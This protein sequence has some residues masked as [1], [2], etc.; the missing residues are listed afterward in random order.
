MPPPWLSPALTWRQLGQHS[1]VSIRNPLRRAWNQDFSF[2]FEFQN[3]KFQNYYY[4]IQY[5]VVRLPRHRVPVL[6]EVE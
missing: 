3:F 4:E 5:V 6:L 2:S 1:A